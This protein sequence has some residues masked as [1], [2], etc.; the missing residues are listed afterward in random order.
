M[1]VEEKEETQKYLLSSVA[2]SLVT[3]GENFLA[4]DASELGFQGMKNS[5]RITCYGAGR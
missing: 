5:S 1:E 3:P 2:L 4:D